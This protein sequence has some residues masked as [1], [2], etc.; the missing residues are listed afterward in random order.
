VKRNILVVGSST[1]AKA[2][3]DLGTTYHYVAD[4]ISD[5]KSFS[6]VLFTGGADV[7]PSFYGEQSED[8]CFTNLERDLQ[9]AHI[10]R[11][12]KDN[13]VKMAGICRGLQ[14]INVMAGGRLMHHID[15]HDNAQHPFECFK[16]NV[17]R[18][19]NSFHH[20]M[21]IPGPGCQIVGWCPEKRSKVY[22]GNNDKEVLWDGPE[23]EAAIYPEFNACGVQWHPEWM[24]KKDA[25]N[26]FFVNMVSNLLEL[27]MKDLLSIYAEK[28]ELKANG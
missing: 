21:I 18:T 9:E 15:R 20:Q 27:S 12:A 10:F 23:L 8:M 6:L 13:N 4:F 11:V 2:V 3:E 14:F 16:D 17:I 26:M 22:Y 7:D 24:L 5:P 1:Y 25:G 28:K 19:V